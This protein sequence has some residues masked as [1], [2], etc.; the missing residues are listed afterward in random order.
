LGRLSPLTRPI[1]GKELYLYLAASDKAINPVL[2]REEANVQ[3]LVF[4][5]I[6]ND[7][8]L[9]NKQ[10]EKVAYEVVL[11]ARKLRP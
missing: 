7:T 6:L 2:V 4:S 8:K 9:G 11:S 10:I 1:Q 5:K 3:R